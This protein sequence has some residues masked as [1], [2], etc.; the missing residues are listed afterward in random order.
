MWFKKKKETVETIR[1]ELSAE[2]AGRD[3]MKKIIDRAE[4]ISQHYIDRYISSVRRVAWLEEQL[5]IAQEKESTC[6][7][8]N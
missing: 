4:S 1:C 5:V 3:A 6:Q 7:D 8:P 2:K